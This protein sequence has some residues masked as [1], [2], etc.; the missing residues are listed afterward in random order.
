MK[1]YLAF[2]VIFTIA[3]VLGWSIWLATHGTTW[4]MY[5]A[6]FSSC[7]MFYRLGCRA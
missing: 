6:I 4:V 7:F 2:L 1:F 3:L 5:L